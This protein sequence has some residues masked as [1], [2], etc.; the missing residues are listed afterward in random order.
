MGD[1][2]I[3]GHVWKF[4][5]AGLYQPGRPGEPRPPVRGHALRRA[6]QGRRDGRVAPDPHGHAARSRPERARSQA[7][8]PVRA[9]S[10]WATFTRASAR[11]SM[12][13]YRAANAVG[14]TPSGRPED[15]EVHPADGSVFIAFT[16]SS[17]RPGLWPNMLRRGLA[18]RRGRRR[19]ARARLPLV[20]LLRRRA[21]PT[22]RAPATSSPSRTTSCSTG[23]AISGWPPTSRANT[24]TRARPTR[25]SRT[26]AVFRI[27]VTGPDRGRALAVRLPALR[28]GGDRPRLRP[29]G[30]ARSSSPSSIPG[31]RYGTRFSS[32]D[33]PRGSNWPAR[34]MGTPPQPAVV[35]MRRR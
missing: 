22:R 32:S 34:R 15:V 26:P 17:D 13:A 28:V 18:A 9:R 24:S 3:G 5:S 19:P 27:P 2:R 20:A 21:R 10:A 11:R 14:G 6:L 16:A 1:D 25:P 7:A 35:A 8:D 33:A 23:A 4:V 12:D 29:R 30:E 31:E